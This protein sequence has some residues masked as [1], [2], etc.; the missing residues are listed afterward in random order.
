[1][2]RGSLPNHSPEEARAMVRY[3]FADPD[4]RV[5]SCTNADCDIPFIGMTAEDYA[6]HLVE[7]HSFY[8]R[9]TKNALLGTVSRA[10]SDGRGDE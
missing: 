2:P 6:A 10:T 9:S 5:E 4:V 3:N 7:H 8:R 1:M